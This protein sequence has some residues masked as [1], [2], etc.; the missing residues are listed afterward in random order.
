MDDF[1]NHVDLLDSNSR[2]YKG[3][4]MRFTINGNTTKKYRIGL[5]KSKEIWFEAT[6]NEG[7]CYNLVKKF[8]TL[9]EAM[10]FIFNKDCP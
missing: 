1:F 8:D 10:N 4:I 7:R 9:N 2:K 3:V 5:C 6:N